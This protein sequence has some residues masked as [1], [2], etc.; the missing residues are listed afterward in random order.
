MAYARGIVGVK[1]GARGAL[2]L[3]RVEAPI[4]AIPVAPVVSHDPTG[5]GDT[6]CGAFL[7]SLAQ[8]HDA[9][10]AGCRAAAAASFAV[11]GPGIVRVLTAPRQRLEARL[12][13]IRTRAGS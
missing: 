5:A 11:E 9:L 13:G 1:L 7:A 10:E 12:A 3:A 8:G 6:F 2:L 4:V